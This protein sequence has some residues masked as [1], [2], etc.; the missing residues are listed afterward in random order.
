MR[1]ARGGA[2]RWGGGSRGRRG[3]QGPLMCRCRTWCL[4]TLCVLCFLRSENRMKKLVCGRRQV[5][6]PDTGWRGDFCM[7]E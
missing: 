2:G 7:Q 6:L 3:P 1:Q 4:R 5:A